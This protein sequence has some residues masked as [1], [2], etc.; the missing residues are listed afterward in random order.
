MGL[1]GFCL[2]M[3]QVSDNAEALV[4][5]IVLGVYSMYMNV[6]R[7]TKEENVYLFIPTSILCALGSAQNRNRM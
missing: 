1:T 3:S 4:T 6:M 7:S 5:R 2:G